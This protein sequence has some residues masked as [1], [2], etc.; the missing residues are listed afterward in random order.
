MPFSSLVLTGK[1]KQ[2]FVG[3]YFRIFVVLIISNAL[4][5]IKKTLNP[6][7]NQTFMID[8]REPEKLTLEIE[9]FDEDRFGK[10]FGLLFCILTSSRTTLLVLLHSHSKIFQKE[11]RLPSGL[12]SEVFRM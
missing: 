4:Q 2:R 11:R 8:L 12:V 10:V 9:V 3:N 6:H 7:W 5:T 1:Q